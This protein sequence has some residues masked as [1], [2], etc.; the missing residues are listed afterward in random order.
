MKK[1]ILLFMTL[2]LTIGVMQSQVKIGQDAVPEKGAILDL[3]S[4]VPGG[5]LL[6]NVNI[7]DLKLIPASFTDV[8]DKDNAPDLAGMLVWNTNPGTGEGVYMWDGANWKLL[9]TDPGINIGDFDDD[10]TAT[11]AGIT[12]SLTGA[13]CFDVRTSLVAS[14][15]YALTVT[16]ATV[17]DVT[18]LID[19][20]KSVQSS[21]ASTST[22]GA[23]LNFKPQATVSGLAP[24]EIVINALVTMMQGANEYKV[25]VKR[26]VKFQE[27]SCCEGAIIYNGAYTNAPMATGQ[28]GSW[29]SSWTGTGFTAKGQDLCWN[30]TDASASIMQWAPAVSSCSGDWRLPN[31]R[32]LHELYKTMG[33]AGGSTVSFADIPAGL[34]SNP[35]S[36][37]NLLNSN[38]WSSTEANASDAYYFAFSNGSRVS[39]Y[40]TINRYVRCVRNL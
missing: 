10:G 3:N 35:G 9:K 20:V 22:F 12:W 38:Y 16:G 28:D 40:K 19:D 24:A 31:L 23:T 11:T 1:I 33:G 25:A 26:T 21:P 36:A 30:K 4:G 15:S 2:F 39:W 17:T 6:P 5:L 14:S 8:T 27:Q 7:A 37:D 29:S 34:G 18:W 13:T 32:E